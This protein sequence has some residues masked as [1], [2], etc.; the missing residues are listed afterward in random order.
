M[1]PKT[2]AALIL[3]LAAQLTEEARGDPQADFKNVSL[4]AYIAECTAYSVQLCQFDLGKYVRARWADR[5][6]AM[7]EETCTAR[8]GSEPLSDSDLGRRIW[9]WLGAHPELAGSN[10]SEA[11]VS[12]V[13]AE[14]PCVDEM[15]APNSRGAV[16][17]LP[18]PDTEKPGKAAG[19]SGP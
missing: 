15:V 18:A 19:S 11:F 8:V 17:T 12:A 10:A 6:G 7:T 3:A 2:A 9:S 4:S 5:H 14:Y 13:D 16:Q 1:G